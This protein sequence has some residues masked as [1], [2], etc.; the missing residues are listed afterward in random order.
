MESIVIYK[1]LDT[2]LPWPLQ[3]SNIVILI[4][5]LPP[6]MIQQLYRQI[7]HISMFNR[8]LFENSVKELD[9][10]LMPESYMYLTSYHQVSE[11]IQTNLMSFM[12]INKIIHQYIG[13]SNLYHFTSNPWP[14][15]PK[16][17]LWFQISWGDLITMP[18]IM[19]TL[20]STL[21]IY[22]WI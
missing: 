16:S 6:E 1:W 4:I 8:R 14:L 21:Q 11:E 22:S 19:V 3:V 12:V 7:L 20:R 9:T 17:F 18:L 2:Q 5:R 13:K 10:R 15:L